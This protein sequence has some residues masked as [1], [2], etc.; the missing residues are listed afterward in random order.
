MHKV[1]ISYHHS[2]DQF[3]KDELIRQN[4]YNNTFL[5]RSVNDGDISETLSNES[6]RQ[7]IRDDYL[8]DTTVT[9]LLVGKE[10]KHRKH[11]DWEL[12]SSMIDGR[13]NKKSGILV[14]ILP[15]IN[16]SLILTSHLNEKE[17]I[18]PDISYWEDFETKQKYEELCPELP[19][20]I[21]DN[22]LNPEC[23][24]S[25]TP[26]DRINHNSKNLEF[27]IK[28]TSESRLTN[29]YD[30]SRPMRK[31]NYNPSLLGY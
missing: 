5:D 19:E 21:V 26:W 8:Q 30:L 17:Q 28:R 2:N 6:I 31:Q 10:T 20:R 16:N 22:L 29:K 11:V 14:I 3:Y 13:I 27:L 15:S 23:R 24:I 25:V 12:K 4:L 18:Y 7:I 1:F 9:I